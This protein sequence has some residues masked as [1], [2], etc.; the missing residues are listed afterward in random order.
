ML[1]PLQEFIRL[2]SASGILLLIATLAAL[3]TQNSAASPLY[4]AFLNYPLA[5]QWGQFGIAK[6]LLLWINDGL[7][8]IFFLLVGLELKREMLQ[9]ELADP[10]QII[11]PVVAALGG[12][13]VPAIIFAAINWGDAYAMR[14]W[15]IPTAT[16][17]AFALGVLALLGKRVPSALKLFL[18]TLAI[19]DDLGA[20]VIIAAFY[21]ES[22]S[23]LAILV[24][25][26]ALLL[27]LILNIKNVLSL[28]VYLVVG[29]LLWVALLKS[30]IHATLAGV[31]LAFF[32]P[33]RIQKS[34]Q[35]ST[36][37]RVQPEN[38]YSERSPL[39]KLEHRLHASVA[40]GILP[41][42]AFA[43]TGVPLHGMTFSALL[44]P[45]P[46][47]IMAGLFIGKQIGVFGF[48]WLLIKS[49]QASLPNGTTWLALYAVS[50]L[51]GIGFT[52]S[53][54]VSSLAY[55]DGAQ[56]AMSDR[57]GVLCGSL[58]SAVAGLVLLRVALGG[59]AGEK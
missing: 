16:D 49:G 58:L 42:F 30:G 44:A 7:M 48:S 38:S 20:I 12:M 5:V 59:R 26:C 19:V 43:N 39:A 15:A 8:A 17:I 40:F 10:K 1:K 6:P 50:I 36:A 47:G 51:A 28:S 34:A 4:N 18:L 3:L 24:V 13:V 11:L 21:T 57:L 25:A 56:F 52:M 23:M 2:E 29:L 55:G 37:E 22:L 41:L 9:G 27:L 31:M 35:L 33:L 53:L 54:F 32:I 14:G 46:L 45:V